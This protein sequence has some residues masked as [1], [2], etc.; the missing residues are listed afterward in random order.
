M[1][2]FSS[3]ILEIWRVEDKLILK[4]TYLNNPYEKRTPKIKPDI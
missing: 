4:L 3:G 2:Q 1:N